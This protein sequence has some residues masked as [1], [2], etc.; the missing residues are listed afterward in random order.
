MKKDLKLKHKIVID[1]YSDTICPWCY[2]GK[3]KL[4]SAIN[5]FPKHQFN[6]TWRPFQ[7]NPDMPI[8]GMDRKIY[9]NQKFNGSEHATKIYDVI[10]RAGHNIGIHFQFN[11]IIRTPNSFASHKL[12][13]L[14]HKKGKQDQIIE[15]LFYAYFIEG[16]D[17]GRLEELIS[18][19]KHHN[20]NE[21]ETHH[22]ISSDLD[23]PKLLEESVNAK[24]MGIKGVP[25]FII[26]KKYVLFGAQEKEKFIDIF[27]SFS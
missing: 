10:D 27:N 18:I 23:R 13:A 2:I 11:K 20:L 16:R 6:I 15:S 5:L 14:G 1:I 21:D 25:C 4:Q 17:I 7:L 24:N 19:A 22:Y 9:L 8:E 3:R 26:N 12:L